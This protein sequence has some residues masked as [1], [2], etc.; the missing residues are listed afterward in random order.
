MRY[1]SQYANGNHRSAAGDG[2]WAAD[3]ALEDA[4][5]PRD[6]GTSSA[7][8]FGR[9]ASRSSAGVAGGGNG[10]GF[11]FVSRG[12]SSTSTRSRSANGS[13]AVETLEQDWAAMAALTLRAE[14]SAS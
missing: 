10:G 11:G 14:L 4:L 2:Q 12:A 1:D 13:G 8:S 6:L 9:A 7:V 5:H 3:A